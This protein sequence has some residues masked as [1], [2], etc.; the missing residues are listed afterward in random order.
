MKS[1][2]IAAL[3]AGT[4]ALA[5]PAAA[6]GPSF[7]F[8][9]GPSGYTYFSFKSYGHRRHHGHYRHARRRFRH[10]GYRPYGYGPPRFAR[11]PRWRR[12]HWRRRHY[13]YVGQR[14][15]SRGRR[16][17]RGYGHGWGGYGR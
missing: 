7:S 3:A 16:F 10:R 4:L 6:D 5:Q 8:G 15:W 11:G 17:H 9:V 2:A 12:R 13:G 14:R 1:L